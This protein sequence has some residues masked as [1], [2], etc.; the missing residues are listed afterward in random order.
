MRKDKQVIVVGAGISGLTAAAYLLR[1]GF[2][3]TLVEAS[4][5][6]GGLVNSFY[7]D[8]YLFDTG[9][10]A[11]GNA[12]ILEPMLKDL[13]IELELIKGDVTLG[14]ANR[15]VDFAKDS[16]ID[17]YIK[18]LEAEFPLEKSG[19]RKLQR[20][21][22][23]NCRITKTL[24]LIS[25]PIFKNLLIDFKYTFFK[26]LPWLPRFITALI[27][28]ERASIEEVLKKVPLSKPLQDIVS[29]HF[30]KGTPEVFALGYF[31]SFKDY[32]YPLGGTKVLPDSLKKR[33]K[34]LGGD[35]LLNSLV[36][37]V[38]PANK[39]LKIK[40]GKELF[41]DALL[42]T[43]DL[44]SLY[45]IASL[46]KL[47]FK[48]RRAVEIEKNRVIGRRAGE[49]VLSVFIG[50]N[51]EPEYF[52]SISS[53]HLIYTPLTK[54]L[55]NIHREGLD[56][57]KRDFKGLN[58]EG[59]F[60]WIEDFTSL[61]S[62]EISIPVLKDRTLAPHG[63][64]GIEISLIVDGE[65]FKLAKNRGWYSDV[66]K[67]FTKEILIN[68]EKSLYPELSRYIVYTITSTPITLIRRFGSEN[69]AITG[70]SMEEAPPVPSSI[71]ELFNTPK[72]SI[73][74]VY[75]AGQWSYS[76]SGVPIAILTGRVAAGL[77][78]K[79]A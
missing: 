32:K 30:F 46:N 75:K 44:K 52:E 58:K 28:S 73:P 10:R 15:F 78:K 54:G 40:N 25:N 20:R 48:N 53:G 5:D 2:K 49:S 38:Y 9:P 59:L 47:P 29:Q 31:E 64:T 51:R 7:K 35:I 33:V 41:Y 65:I 12:G 36:E 8:G 72:T 63:K 42:W 18:L 19:I 26:L 67:K 68:I 24:N 34:M 55:G 61:N 79:Q 39:S 17:D 56:R 74:G 21:V 62:Y 13:D 70:W 45:R 27:N 3:V 50:V 16:G 60:K 22:R 71:L 76:P 4:S 69:G 43:G 11:I 1:Y 66:K 57:L 23:K 37:R 14:V 77:I 6:T